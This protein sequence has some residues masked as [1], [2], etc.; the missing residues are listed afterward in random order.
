MS[1]LRQLIGTRP[2]PLEV[3]LGHSIPGYYHL[4][5]V[6]DGE[7]SIGVPPPEKMSVNLT[8]DLLTSKSNQFIYVPGC[9]EN[10]NLVK[11]LRTVCKI[12]C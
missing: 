10:I 5:M 7:P 12:S 3:P 9:T 2:S 8:F 11:F 1:D 6:Y 4:N